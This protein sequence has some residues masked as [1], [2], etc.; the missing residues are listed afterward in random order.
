MGVHEADAAE[1]SVGHPRQQQ[2]SL[3]HH[4]PFSNAGLAVQRH[5]LRY[6]SR[7]GGHHIGVFLRVD[8]AGRALPLHHLHMGGAA[9]HI[10]GQPRQLVKFQQHMVA[11]IFL[12]NIQRPRADGDAVALQGPQ[13][14]RV[15]HPRI[16][17]D[18]KG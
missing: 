12:F 5:D 7:L 2:L 1:P 4:V 9:P 10:D 8:D 3:F 18:G 6:Q 14:L 17:A 13:N 11:E 15:R 16:A